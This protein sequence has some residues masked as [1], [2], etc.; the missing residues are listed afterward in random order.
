MEAPQYLSGSI[1]NI[2][3]LA[4]VLGFPANEIDDIAYKANRFYNPNPPVPKADGTVRQ[5]YSVKEPLKT[6][7]GQLG[8]FLSCNVRF[9]SYLQGGIKGTD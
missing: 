1:N 2:E 5:T 7:Q 4:K 6:I 9:P 8:L 3:D